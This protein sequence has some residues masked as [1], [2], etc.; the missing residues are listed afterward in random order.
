MT[1]DA[2]FWQ[3]YREHGPKIYNY[4]V[5]FLGNRQDAEDLTGNILIK[6]RESIGSLRET[7]KTRQWLW[8]IARNAAKNFIRDRKETVGLDEA[9]EMHSPFSDNGHRTIR[10]KAALG[11]LE[12]P[13]REII[14]L[15]EYQ[16]FSYAE[17]AELLETSVSGIKSRLYR[18]R[19]N[20]RQEFFQTES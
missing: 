18:A 6:A 10:L 16:D 1:M 20:L 19:E 17:L 8:A 3:A 11:R 9:P 15:R 7:A 13:D 2:E 5:W 4:L 12:Q 14:F